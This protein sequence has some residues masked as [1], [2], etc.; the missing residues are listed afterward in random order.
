MHIR[1]VKLIGVI[2]FR[3]MELISFF[4]SEKVRIQDRLLKNAASEEGSEMNNNS[5]VE[6]VLNAKYDD[7][8]K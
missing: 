3:I 4:V 5:D 6:D 2:I 1:C 8:N 7:R